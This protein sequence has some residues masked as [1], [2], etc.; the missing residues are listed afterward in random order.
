MIVML[1]HLSDMKLAVGVDHLIYGWIFFGIII[2]AL[3]FIGSFWRDPPAEPIRPVVRSK[4]G[5]RGPV[6]AVGVIAVAASVLWPGLAWTIRAEADGDQSVAVLRPDA[7]GLWRP[8]ERAAW[9]WRPQIIGADGQRHDFF[10]RDD[11][12]PVSLFLYTY[13][14]QRQGAELLNSQNKMSTHE[15]PLWT[16]KEQSQRVIRLADEAVAVN[17]SRLEARSGRRLLVWNWYRIGDHH[18]ANPYLGKLMEAWSLLVAGRR[19]G[20]LIVVA[21]P[22]ADREDQAAESLQAFVDAMLPAIDGALDQALSATP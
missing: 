9:E 12:A 1:A 14:T 20:S 5:R 7:S 6:V 8:S 2:T 17:Q 16:E 18:T 4:D 3:F 11:G 13:R 21:A 22:Y 19:D 15:D 10:V